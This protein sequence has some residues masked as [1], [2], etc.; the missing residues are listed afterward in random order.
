V[1][2]YNRVNYSSPISI[3]HDRQLIFASGRR[4]CVTW[5]SAARL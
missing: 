3:R 1:Y 5:P 4:C 2:Q